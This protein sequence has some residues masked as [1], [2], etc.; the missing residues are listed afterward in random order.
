VGAGA[1][2]ALLIVAT[3]G[4]ADEAAAVKVFCAASCVFLATADAALGQRPV[5]TNQAKQRRLEPKDA[6]GLQTIERYFGTVATGGVVILVGLSG[7]GRALWVI[8]P[9]F[10]GDG[11]WDK[12]TVVLLLGAGIF[13]IALG[14][15]IAQ[16][17][18]QGKSL[19]RWLA[20]I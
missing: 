13:M 1:L 12:V 5:D 16:A 9:V 14:V 6:E 8:R 17:G 15:G 4:R 11:L 7:I 10:R 2:L 20:D 19:G 3:A 18:W